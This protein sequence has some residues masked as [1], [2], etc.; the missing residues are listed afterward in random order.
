MNGSELIAL[1]LRSCEL[2]RT[3]RGVFARDSFT[4][5]REDIT[6]AFV[7][8]QSDRG[9]GGTHWLS[10]FIYEKDGRKSCVFFDS[11]GR[12]G[13]DEYN[14]TLPSKN[15]SDEPQHVV[16]NIKRFQS[17]SSNSCGRFCLYV[18]HWLSVGV[19]FETILKDF[20]TNSVSANEKKVLDFSIALKNGLLL[21]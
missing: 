18:L 19:T 7:V 9:S 5:L 6:G 13:L 14:I 17:E 21:C 2:R 15:G 11:L 8:N 12:G 1:A 4:D 10:I 16:Y 3:F 20:S